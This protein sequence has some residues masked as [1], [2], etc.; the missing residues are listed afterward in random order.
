MVSTTGDIR[1][2]RRTVGDG[3]SEK[4][5]ENIDEVVSV[6]EYRD[7]RRKKDI[8]YIPNNVEHQT[9]QEEIKLFSYF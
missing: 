4:T 6:C 8:I 9:A 3:R 1:P 7:K 5:G 2:V